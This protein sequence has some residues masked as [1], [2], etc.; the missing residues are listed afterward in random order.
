[1]KKLKKSIL[2]KKLKAINIDAFSIINSMVFIAVLTM[3]IFSLIFTIRDCVNAV[4]KTGY[5][6]QIVQRLLAII[7]ISIPSLLR[8]I[9]KIKFTKAT[10]A[11]FYAFMFFAS[12]LGTF[13]GFYQKY[14]FYDMIIH[15]VFGVLTALF[16]I[17][18]INVFLKRQ[19]N[20]KLTPF[21]MFFVCFSFSMCAG[22]IW[23]I[24]EFLGDSFFDL[25]KQNFQGATMFVGQHALLDTMTDLICNCAGA[26][27]ASL[28]ISICVVY[29]ES[30][31]KSF[32]IYKAKKK[33]CLIEDNIED[34]NV[35][36]VEDEKQEIDEIEE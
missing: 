36:D 29:C 34:E 17:F 7:V 30:F 10:T 14:E 16:A 27:V 18:L 32:Q 5:A 1:M 3:F 15:F 6:A 35:E 22:A 9:F 25:N 12:Y 23:E 26:L 4:D 2:E 8:W 20:T 11:I 24:Y 21:M 33:H 13:L 31:I 28:I 19:P